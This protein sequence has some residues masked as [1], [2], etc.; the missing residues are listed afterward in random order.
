MRVIVI[1][2]GLAGLRIDRAAHAR[3]RVADECL[4]GAV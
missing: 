3:E 4:S 2:A 1:G